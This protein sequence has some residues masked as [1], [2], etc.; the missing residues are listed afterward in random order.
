MSPCANLLQG[1]FPK[2]PKADGRVTSELCQSD[3]RGQHLGVQTLALEVP[4]FR[5]GQCEHWHQPVSG[6]DCEPPAWGAEAQVWSSHR[7]AEAMGLGA[8]RLPSSAQNIP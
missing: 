5:Q 4:L 2:T 7:G 8:S 3:R 1:T 6:E